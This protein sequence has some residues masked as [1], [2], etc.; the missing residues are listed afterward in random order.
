MVSRSLLRVVV[1]RLMRKQYEK[2]LIL[3]LRG[4]ITPTNFDRGHQRVTNVV[5]V[6]SGR[7]SFNAK[8]V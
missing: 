1:T 8:T 7:D 6:E 4:S 2:M 3:E 5:V